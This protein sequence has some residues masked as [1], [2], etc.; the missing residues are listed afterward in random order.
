MVGVVG[1]MLRRSPGEAHNFI[2]GYALGYLAGG[3]VLVTVAYSVG[4]FL[5]AVLP[6]G[7]RIVALALILVVLGVL[8][9]IDRTPH[10]MRQVPQR[11]A[12]NISPGWRGVVWAFDLALLFTTRK[13]TS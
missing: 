5:D 10:P 9:L 12:R 6:Q 4:R 11:H 3:T 8:D 1:P 7:F 2:L 13:T